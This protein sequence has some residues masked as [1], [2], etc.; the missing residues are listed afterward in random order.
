MQI[1]NVPTEGRVPRRAWGCAA[2]QSAPSFP[3]ERQPRRRFA[4]S[5]TN[6]CMYMFFFI[7]QQT[8]SMWRLWKF[9][10]GMYVL[11]VC[12][13]RFSLL[14]T[15]LLRTPILTR[16]THN[17]YIYII[18]NK[19]KINFTTTIMVKHKPTKSCSIIVAS[20][21]NNNLPT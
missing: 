3:S 21:R 5:V 19:L 6:I 1:K 7:F 17:L 16:F 9:K 18:R 2:A 20:R 12:E 15:N 14:Y 11:Y 13:K 4:V 10:K 8:K